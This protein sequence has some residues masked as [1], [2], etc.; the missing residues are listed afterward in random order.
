MML[1]CV[2]VKRYDREDERY[3][4]H[5]NVSII[6]TGQIISMYPEPTRI[7]Q[8]DIVNGTFKEDFEH[9]QSEDGKISVY[10]Y[11]RLACGLLQTINTPRFVVA[12][13]RGHGPLYTRQLEH[14]VVEHRS[15]NQNQRLQR[16][17]RWPSGSP[18]SPWVLAQGRKGLGTIP[19]E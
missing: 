9:T 17:H 3:G 1:L 14:G 15:P 13:K 18:L 11:L 5:F 4:R 12:G 19:L 2:P 6:G 7:G 16:G 8:V 10:T